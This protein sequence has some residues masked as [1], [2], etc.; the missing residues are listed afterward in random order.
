M[1]AYQTAA[2]TS[3]IPEGE[4]RVVQVEGRSVALCH[5]AGEGFYAIDNLCTH[6]GGPLGDGELQGDRIACP[7][8]G[9]LFDVKT[10]QAR[11]LPAIG[12][13]R[14]YG[15]RLDGDSVQVEID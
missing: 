13:V 14:T 6:D 4:A 5:V 1:S 11:T 9:A 7:R 8:H 3:D 12:K 2:R 15:V 10:G